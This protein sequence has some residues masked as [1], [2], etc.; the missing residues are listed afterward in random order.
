MSGFNPKWLVGKVVKRVQT[1]RIRPYP[2]GNSKM[3]CTE[4]QLIEF[5]DGATLEFVS[6]EKEHEAG[7]V[8]ANYFPP[9]KKSK[10]AEKLVRKEIAQMAADVGDIMVEAYDAEGNETS[11]RQFRASEF[12]AAEEFY[13]RHERAALYRYSGWEMD[14]SKEPEEEQRIDPMEKVLPNQSV[15]YTIITEE[16]YE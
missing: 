16:C 4:F 11:C 6:L 15:P 13:C 12:N 10:R 5:S 1:Q 3:L 8:Y 2:E 14:R 7:M 9:P